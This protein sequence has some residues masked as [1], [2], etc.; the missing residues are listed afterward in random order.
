MSF[1][2]IKPI[3]GRIASGAS[4]CTSI[5][6]GLK[7]WQKVMVEVGTMSTAVNLDIYGSA[8][9]VIFKQ[10]FERVNTA[11]A[12]QWQSFII[13][14]TVGANGGVCVLETPFPY[15]QFRGTAVVSGGV[16]FTLICA[17]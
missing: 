6:L 17:D 14:Q 15:L 5:D 8:D 3:Y 13:S 2:S 10:L 9:N 1:G 7:G 12:A 11:T 16:S 4:T